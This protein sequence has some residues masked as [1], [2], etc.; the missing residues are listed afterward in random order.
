MVPWAAPADR[1][2]FGKLAVSESPTVVRLIAPSQHIGL[3][4]GLIDTLPH[5][6]SRGKSLGLLVGVPAILLRDSMAGFFISE[7]LPNPL[8][9]ARKTYQKLGDLVGV[10]S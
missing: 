4:Q 10:G 7:R 5:I 1:A 6:Y 9:V 2:G 3:L 8:Q